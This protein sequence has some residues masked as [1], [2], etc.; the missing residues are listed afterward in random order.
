MVMPRHVYAIRLG[1]ATADQGGCCH[2]AA[3]V[4]RCM[5]WHKQ[6]NNPNGKIYVDMTM[7]ASINNF[8]SPSDKAQIGWRMGALGRAETAG[9]VNGDL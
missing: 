2:W 7:T 4:S 5:S 1:V 9:L 8:G 3:L 6:V